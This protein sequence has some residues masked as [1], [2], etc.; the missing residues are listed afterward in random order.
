MTQTV[1]EEYIAVQI[2]NAN[3]KDKLKFVDKIEQENKQ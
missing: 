1:L 3:V 2:A